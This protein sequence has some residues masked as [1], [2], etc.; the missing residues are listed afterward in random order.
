MQGL[1]LMCMIIRFFRNGINFT[2]SAAM[3]RFCGV[4]GISVLFD[5]NGRKF[6]LKN[7]NFA[8][9]KP[10]VCES[11]SSGGV[12]LVSDAQIADK[13]DNL[14]YFPEASL[15]SLKSGDKVLNTVHITVNEEALG[16]KADYM[17]YDKETNTLTMLC[18]ER[19]LCT[20]VID[21]SDYVKVWKG[22][23]SDY[24]ALTTIDANT[25][26]CVTNNNANYSKDE[27][28]RHNQVIK[29]YLGIGDRMIPPPPTADD[30]VIR[31]RQTDN[32]RGVYMYIAGSPLDLVTIN[33]GS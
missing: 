14:E 33:W 12:V 32:T 5:I 27:K 9:V 26:Y 31:V 30:I 6:E 29:Q 4:Y 8:E 15:L 21:L 23:Q 13:G 16:G 19:V 7:P 17:T 2:F 18:G 1:R 22:Y 25:M 10:F 24:D 3:Q 20:A 28:Q 11:V